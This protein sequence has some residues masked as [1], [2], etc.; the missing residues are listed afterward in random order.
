MKVAVTGHRPN[1]LNNE[2]DGIGPYSD[3]IRYHL[4]EVIS[5]Y[6]V[7]VHL[8][9]NL[10]LI[11]GMALGVD[12][13]WAELAIANNIPFI[14][15]IPCQG[16]HSVWPQKSKERYLDLI[17]H[18]LCTKMYISIGEYSPQ[19]MQLRNKWM[20]DNCNLL[21]AVWDG[22]T[23]GTKNCYNY[24]ISVNKPV[25]RINPAPTDEEL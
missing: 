24:A 22:T 11:S 19:K 23:G 7:G 12:M 14:A 5:T 13:I 20:V 3:H 25:L 4:Q 16:Q 10:T 8:G 21:V 17:D 2:Y 1:K 15:A 18:P 9:M 6:T